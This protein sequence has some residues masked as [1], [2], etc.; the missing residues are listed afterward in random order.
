[1]RSRIFEAAVRAG[2]VVV[3]AVLVS[4]M[5]CDALYVE[6]PGKRRYRPRCACPRWRR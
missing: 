6:A 1:M 4:C 3:P 2:M 5:T